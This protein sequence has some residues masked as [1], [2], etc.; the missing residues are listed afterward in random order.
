MSAPHAWHRHRHQSR[1]KPHAFLFLAPKCVDHDALHRVTPW[2]VIPC[3]CVTVHSCLSAR[4][5]ITWHRGRHRSRSCSARVPRCSQQATKVALQLLRIFLA[6]PL[7]QCS[8][9]CGCRVRTVRVRCAL[10]PHLPNAIFESGAG[11]GY[12]ARARRKQGSK[13]PKSPK[14]PKQAIAIEDA[15]DEGPPVA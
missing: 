3:V 2:C 10:L 1:F 15:A 14:S 6:V 4:S 11:S 8:A 13:T 7:L 5:A 12:A 9:L